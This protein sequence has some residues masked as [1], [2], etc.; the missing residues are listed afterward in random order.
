[1]DIIRYDIYIIYVYNIIPIVLPIII[2]IY[3][4]L[5]RPSNLQEQAAAKAE[6][7]AKAAEVPMKSDEN[8]EAICQSEFGL[9]IASQSSQLWLTMTDTDN[10][11][12]HYIK[13]YN[14]FADNYAHNYHFY[15]QPIQAKAKSAETSHSAQLNPSRTATIDPCASWCFRDTSRRQDAVRNRPCCSNGHRDGK[16]ATA[17]SK[18]LEARVKTLK[19]CEIMWKNAT[20]WTKWTW[21]VFRMGH[22][23]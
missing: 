12:W 19:E 2:P 8:W 1:M 15:V 22:L 13:C 7:A 3:H 4:R 6:K 9:I 10:Y 5:R 23:I 16:G 14:W 18:G 20:K 11:I 17:T 21:K